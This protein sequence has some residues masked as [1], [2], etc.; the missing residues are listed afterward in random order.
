MRQ[1]HAFPPALRRRAWPAPALRCKLPALPKLATL[2]AVRT[3][4]LL[5]AITGA[6]LL[7]HAQAL[8][9]PELASGLTEKPGW[10]THSYAVAAAN[11]LA[12]QAGLEILQAGGSAVDAAIAVQMVLTLVEPQSSGIGGGAFLLHFDGQQTQAYDGRE[13]APALATPSLFLDAA[14][15]P[16]PFMD[17]V[18]GGRSVGVPGAVRMLFQAHQTHGKL[19]W[20]VLFEPA[21]RL[22]SDGFVVS[23]RMATLLAAELALKTDAQAL[24]YFFDAQGK[25]WPAGHVLRNPELAAVLQDVAEQG[26]GR[27]H[28]RRSGA[29]PGAQG[30]GACQR[31]DADHGRSRRLPAGGACSAVF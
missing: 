21:I 13:T 29:G 27:P 4:A 3:L 14:G 11:P 8:A 1:W 20:K 6:P 22:A 7:S 25:P 19:P 18:V 2:F 23:P 5:A 9:Q 15:K 12:T 28:D 17:A 10:A 24:A 31:G 30:A 16:L 26:A